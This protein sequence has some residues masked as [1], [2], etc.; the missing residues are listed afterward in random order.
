MIRS[1]SFF[2]LSNGCS[3]LNDDVD[4]ALCGVTLD[5]IGLGL[6][7]VDFLDE[8]GIAERINNGCDTQAGMLEQEM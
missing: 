3:F 8:M 4:M 6:E 7:S 2:L 1:A 5:W